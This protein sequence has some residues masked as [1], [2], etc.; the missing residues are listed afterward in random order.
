MIPKL[1][2]NYPGAERIADEP[3]VFLFEDYLSQAE[4]DHLI[5]LSAANMK[6]AVVSGGTEGV[7]SDGRTGGVHWLLHDETPITLALSRRIAGLVGLPLD[8]AESLQV[9]NYGPGE[10]YRSHYD[11]WVPGTETGDRCMSRG[12]QRLVTCLMYLESAESGGYT[13]FPRLDIEV[14][15]RPRRMLLF[16]NCYP[17]TVERHPGALHGGMAPD[18]GTKWAC[19]LWFRADR[20][21]DPCPPTAISGN[22]TT[23]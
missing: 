7:E 22:R 18:A 9:I 10:E 16:H 20:F 2:E 23:S 19:N 3:P 17:G 21:R 12:G 4:C 14:L 1:R 13:F 5:E 11:A 8:N 6:R 15:P